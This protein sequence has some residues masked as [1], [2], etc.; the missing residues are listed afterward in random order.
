MRTISTALAPTP[1]PQIVAS[2]ALAIPEPSCA[3]SASVSDP[4]LPGAGAFTGH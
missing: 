3:M 2:G 1:Y 4:T